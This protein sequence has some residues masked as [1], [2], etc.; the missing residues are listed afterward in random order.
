FGHY[1]DDRLGAGRPDDQPA[2]TIETALAIGDR[3]LDA[4]VVQ[5]CRRLA[6]AL[7]HLRHRLEPAA[8]L[9]HRA[10]EALDNGEDLERGHETVAR[11]A[12]VRQDDVARLLAGDMEAVRTNVLDDVAVDDAGARHRKAEAGKIA[13]EAE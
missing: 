2:A 11:G 4:G 1:P 12:V 5:R 9:A 10:A 3:A 8:D 7:E 6:H 13:F